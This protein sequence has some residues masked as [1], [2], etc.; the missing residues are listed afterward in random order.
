M[1]YMLLLN[2]P[3]KVIKSASI[4]KKGYIE[5]LNGLMTSISPEIIKRPVL[6]TSKADKS[7]CLDSL[8][9]RSKFGNDP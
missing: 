3:G 5:P 8:N 9:I 2:K 1:I 6:Q 7:I 4:Q